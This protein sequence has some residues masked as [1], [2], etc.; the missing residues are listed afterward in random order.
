VASLR[1]SV[2][3]EALR[4]QFAGLG[5]ETRETTMNS[6]Y[7]PPNECLSCHLRGGNFFCA[8][9]RTSIKALNEIKLGA[10][11]PEG[12]VILSEGQTPRGV[13]MLCQGQAKL[14]ITAKDG[15][16]FILRIAKPGEV[17]GLHAVVTGRPYEMTVET[18]QPCLLN[19]VSR[20]NFLRFLNDHSDACLHA[21]QHISRDYQTACD[22][23][24]SV[25]LTHSIS[26]RLAKFLLESSADGKVANGV[27]RTKLTLTHEEISQLVGTTRETITRLLSDFRK[28]E[29][30][31]LRGSTLVIHNK[32]AL[33][34]LIA[35]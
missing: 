4:P 2:D 33:E 15:K 21:L 12:V 14:S 17:L 30:A 23:L 24:R 32:P 16:T 28:R 29:L 25:G 10:A 26:E 22:A 20:D 1:F 5:P 9:S 11:F 27:V 13:F 18:M 6:R 34:R 31:E 35:S 8:L 7:S 19:L 3:H